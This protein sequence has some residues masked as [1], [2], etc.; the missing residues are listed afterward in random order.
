MGGLAAGKDDIVKLLARVT[1]SK[2]GQLLLAQVGERYFLLGNTP[3]G[4]TKLAEFT[5]EEAQAWKSNE[6]P[7][8]GGQPPSFGEALR[9][10]WKQKVKR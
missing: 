8:G 4:I 5:P 2:D 3:A 10:V 9:K 1:V 7:S 6:D